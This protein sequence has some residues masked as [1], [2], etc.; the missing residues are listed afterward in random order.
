LVVL[1]LTIKGLADRFGALIA[2]LILSPLLLLISLLVRWRLGSPVLFRQQRPGYRGRPFWLLKFRT[3]TN[4]RDTNGALLP[5][6][7]RLTILGR[8]LRATCAAR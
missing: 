1:Y 6:A 5:D 4:A 3:M 8:W 2:L 7:Q